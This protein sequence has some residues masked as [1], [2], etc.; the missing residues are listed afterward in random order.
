MKQ[1]AKMDEAEKMEAI[2][3]LIEAA[4]AKWMKRR[5]PQRLKLLLS[6]RRQR[7]ASVRGRTMRSTIKRR[8]L[9]S[10]FL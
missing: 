3:Q 2:N 1:K 9:K 7:K 5:K 4:K 10:R 8:N 6:S